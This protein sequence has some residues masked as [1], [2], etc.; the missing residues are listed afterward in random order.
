MKKVRLTESDLR[1]IITKILKEDEIDLTSDI[2]L[3]KSHSDIPGCDPQRLDFQRCT[4]EAFKTLPAPEFVALFEKLSAQS[5][6]ELENPLSTMAE[7]RRRLGRK[8]NR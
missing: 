3:F 5:P 1:R 4:T 6:E 2:E 7:S 8:L